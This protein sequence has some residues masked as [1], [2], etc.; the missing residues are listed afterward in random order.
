MRIDSI[1]ES[2]ITRERSSVGL[3]NIL[4]YLHYVLLESCTDEHIHD[5]CIIGMPNW[6]N[7]LLSNEV[8]YCTAT[9]NH[10]ISNH[11]SSIRETALMD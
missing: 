1:T 5:E 2:Q 3:S 6:T 10:I 9:L 4:R 8:Y 11:R 7:T